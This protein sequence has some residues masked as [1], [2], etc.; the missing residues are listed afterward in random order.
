MIGEVRIN[1]L[2]LR[3]GNISFIPS[4]QLGSLVS[5]VTNIVSLESWGVTGLDYEFLLDNIKSE[6]LQIIENPASHKI[7]ALVRAM[8]TRVKEV[9]IIDD[10]TVDIKGSLKKVNKTKM[11]RNGPKCFESTQSSSF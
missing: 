8:Q 6:V 5:R 10:N 4:E 1:G 2:T 3:R 7:L 9:V 11:T